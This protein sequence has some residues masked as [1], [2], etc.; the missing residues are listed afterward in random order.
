[1][2]LI[3][4]SAKQIEYN[5]KES[6]NAYKSVQEITAKLNDMEFHCAPRCTHF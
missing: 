2:A 5:F 1:M 4:I 3:S 6:H